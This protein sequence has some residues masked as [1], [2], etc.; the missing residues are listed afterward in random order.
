[1]E[2]RLQARFSFRH[3]TPLS[4]FRQRWSAR[5]LNLPRQLRNEKDLAGVRI[6]HFRAWRKTFNVDILARRER[7]LDQIFLT[8][9]RNSV[10]KIAFRNFR[11]RRSGRRSGRCR[12][13]LRCSVRLRLPV[14]IE[15]L[16]LRRI[17]SSLL[18]FLRVVRYMMTNARWRL[19]RFA[20]GKKEKAEQGKAERK[21][22]N[23]SFDEGSEL[24]IRCQ[25]LKSAPTN[26]D[27]SQIR[28]K[29]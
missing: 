3:K 6:F 14:W 21:F 15:R 26:R 11:R 16:L 23:G 18:R 2:Q 7:T 13:F 20:R 8:R 29:L 9:D 28:A 1:M 12:L 17:L 10:W 27:K 19:I 25:S 5:Q 4:S 24:L 22:H